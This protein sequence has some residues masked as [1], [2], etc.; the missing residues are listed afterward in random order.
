MSLRRQF[1][2]RIFGRYLRSLSVDQTQRLLYA[3]RLM[4]FFSASTLA[5]VLFQIK[6]KYEAEKEKEKVLA[7]VPSVAAI[8]VVKRPEERMAELE[9][10]KRGTGG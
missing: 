10:L 1:A 8:K 5:I 6:T 4:Y 9:A 7:N 3:M 2:R